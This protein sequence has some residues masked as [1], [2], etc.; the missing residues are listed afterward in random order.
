MWWIIKKRNSSVSRLQKYASFL[1]SKRVSV[2]LGSLDMVEVGG[3]TKCDRRSILVAK[4]KRRRPEVVRV[5]EAS[6][7]ET[8]R[9]VLPKLKEPR[10]SGAF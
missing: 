3:S 7:L 8:I 1:V 10:D 9:L 2:S 4:V 5:R 6:A